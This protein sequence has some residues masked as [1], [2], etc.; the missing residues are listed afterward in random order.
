M[1]GKRKILEERKSTI[2][3][4]RDDAD[5]KEAGGQGQV[6]SIATNEREFMALRS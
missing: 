1:D 6:S 4:T 5:Q 2:V 3:W